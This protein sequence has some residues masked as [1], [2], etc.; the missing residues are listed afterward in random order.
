M[1]LGGG[2]QEYSP[3]WNRVSLDG[4]GNREGVGGSELAPV[5]AMSLGGSRSRP[6]LPLWIDLDLGRPPEVQR[7]LKQYTFGLL[8]PLEASRYS[9]YWGS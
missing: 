6:S 5:P 7:M 2:C 1:Q 4:G 9:F 8:A 3:K